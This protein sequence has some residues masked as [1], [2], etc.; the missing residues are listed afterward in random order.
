MGLKYLIFCIHNGKESKEKNTPEKK[1]R[2]CKT[3]EVTTEACSKF[4]TKLPITTPKLAKIP[5]F[6]NV[7]KNKSKI[8]NEII[9]PAHRHPAT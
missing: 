2:G 5:T 4:L 3:N 8:L 1:E 7:V 9:F 6:N